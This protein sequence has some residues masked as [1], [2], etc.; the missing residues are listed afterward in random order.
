MATN[1]TA[2]DDMQ[3]KIPELLVLI[4]KGDEIII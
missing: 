4:S 3:A 2:V 1:I